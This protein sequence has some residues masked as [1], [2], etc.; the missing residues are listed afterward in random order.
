VPVLYH[1]RNP[2]GVYS[3]KCGVYI[4][5]N[6]T[7]QEKRQII[8]R[9]HRIEGQIKALEKLLEKD[10]PELFVGQFLAIIAASQSCLTTYLTSIITT[11]MSPEL[12]SKLLL[13]VIRSS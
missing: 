1:N 11:E 5:D 3:G 12:R 4:G 13:K 2:L 9:L 8:S 7:E 10:D 6:M